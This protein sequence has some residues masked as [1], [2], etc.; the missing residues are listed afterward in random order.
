M[1]T[2]PVI[3]VEYVELSM[4]EIVVLKVMRYSFILADCIRHTYIYRRY[5]F[6]EGNSEQSNAIYA[7]NQSLLI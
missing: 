3:L 1:Y 5:G 6:T 2:S 7:Y 4:T